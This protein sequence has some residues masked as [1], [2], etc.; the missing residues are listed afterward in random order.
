MMREPDDTAAGTG[1]FTFT[2]DR[3]PVPMQD[4]PDGRMQSWLPDPQGYAINQVALRHEQA[5]TFYGEY[6][7]FILM[8]R[9]A[10][11]LKGFVE[12]CSTCW[13][14]DASVGMT[15]EM[16]EVYGQSPRE[17]CPNCF[18]TTF[19]GGY[20]ARIIR[21]ALWDANEATQQ[22]NRRGEVDVNTA[23]VQTTEDFRMRSGDYIFRADGTRWR[24]QTISTNH[25][26]TGFMMPST[27]RT[28]VGY[29]FGQVV[30]EDPAT[31]AYTIDPSPAELADLDMLSARYPHDWAWAENVRG[32]LY[33]DDEVPSG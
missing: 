20:K 31:V 23:S 5:L 2:I 25:L 33:H 6:S 16:A 17:K 24:V 18:G 12:R 10:D 30:R 15:K 4:L 13:R 3:I 7:M 28:P 1:T 8:W 22:S 26:R 9:L 21:L 14:D 27:P 32:S 11:H 29:N 19:E